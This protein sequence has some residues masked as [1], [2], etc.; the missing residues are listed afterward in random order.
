MKALVEVMN[1]A[2]FYRKAQLL[3]LVLVKWVVCKRVHL[4]VSLSV[5]ISHLKAHYTRVNVKG[6]VSWKRL[7]RLAELLHR[8]KLTKGNNHLFLSVHVLLCQ[9]ATVLQILSYQTTKTSSSR[10]KI[11]ENKKSMKIFVFVTH[12]RATLRPQLRKR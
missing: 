5:T 9:I 12:T 4:C 1:T 7:H 10:A 11:H 6:R 8:R 2:L 3:E